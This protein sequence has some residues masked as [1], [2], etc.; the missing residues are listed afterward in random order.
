MRSVLEELAGRFVFN[1]GLL[2]TVADGLAEADWAARPPGGGNSAHWIL[3]H[4]CA[5]RRLLLG[6]LGEVAPG[7]GWE[8]RFGRGSEHGERV[9]APAPAELLAEMRRLGPRLAERLRALSEAEAAR[10]W[11]RA[12]PDGSDTLA[13]G[14][15]FLFFHEAYHLGQI[16]LLRRMRGK[17]GFA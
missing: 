12:F 4:L 1:D 9:D 11:G 3:A 6:K 14:A 13:G 8:E 15:S 16:G 2:A 7:G 10:P 17:P 5:T